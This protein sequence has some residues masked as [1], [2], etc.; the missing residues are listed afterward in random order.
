MVGIHLQKNSNSLEQCF[1]LQVSKGLQGYF[2]LWIIFHQ[3]SVLLV[4]DARDERFLFFKN[5]G[6]LFVGFYFFCSGYGLIVSLEKK[7]HYLK[8][9]MKKRFLMVLVPFFLCNYIYMLATLLLGAEYKMEDLFAAF[10]GVLLLNNQM[11][12]AVEIMILY[13]LFYL[14]FGLIKN[15]KTAFVVINILVLCMMFFSFLLGHDNTS[16]TGGRWFYGEWWYNTTILFLCGMFFAKYRF[17]CEAVIN[18]WYVWLLLIGLLGVS[19]FYCLSSYQLEQ[20]GYWTEYEIMS[21]QMNMQYKDKFITWISQVPMVISFVFVVILI[22]I[23]VRLHN[24]IIA[25]LGKISLEMI[26][27]NKVFTVIFWTLKSSIG[28][29]FFIIAVILATIISAIA[30]NKIKMLVLERK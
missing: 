17:K 22:L 8:G 24:K 9:F 6:V 13:L 4:N 26:L 28:I 10:F 3:I 23:K 7:E 20:R 14:T 2:A 19:I 25:F 30:L 12:F 15:Q 1:S 18:R 29:H 11:W 27:I 5:L 21:N 16:V